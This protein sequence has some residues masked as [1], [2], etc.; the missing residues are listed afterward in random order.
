V[1]VCVR[2]CVCVCLTACA[3]LPPVMIAHIYKLLVTLYS[4]RPK[5][6][7]S[8]LSPRQAALTACALI[9]SSG[10]ADEGEASVMMF[11][12]SFSI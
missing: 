3:L 10:A 7:V 4:F 9:R 12:C 5:Q 11:L 8:Q 6:R 2:V 1:Y